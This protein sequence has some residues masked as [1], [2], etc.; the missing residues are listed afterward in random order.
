MPELQVYTGPQANASMGS[1]GG[2]VTAPGAGAALVT[3]LPPSGK[4]FYAIEVFAYLSAGTPAAADNANIEFRF[5]GTTLSRI[6][7]F[8]ALN[9]LSQWRTTFTSDGV[10]NF[11]VNATGA[12]TGGVTYNVFMTAT[13]L[14]D[15]T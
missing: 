7:L 15:I 4:G 6:P 2:G 11:S 1:S 10:T 14:R 13:K 9:L 5:G 8:P 3:I 12:G